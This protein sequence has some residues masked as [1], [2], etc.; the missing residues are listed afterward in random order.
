METKPIIK[1]AAVITLT[2]TLR[3]R[4]VDYEEGGSVHTE[5]VTVTETYAERD[6]PKLGPPLNCLHKYTL[7]KTK[8]KDVFHQFSFDPYST[9]TIAKII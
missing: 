8:K 2:L 3:P 1:A 4:A 6:T 9:N 7:N 5:K